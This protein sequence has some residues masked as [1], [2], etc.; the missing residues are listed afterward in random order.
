MKKFLC[1]CAVIMTFCSITK[2]SAQ[3]PINAPAPLDPAIRKGVL[4]NGLTYYIRHNEEPKNRASF[5]IVQNV[6]ALLENDSQ[7]GLA[8]FLEHMAFNGTKHFEGKGILNTLQNHGVEFGRNINAYTAFN[9]TVYNLSEVPTTSKGLVDSCLLVL[10]DWS[11]Y[12]A[13]TP[14]EI[15]SERG[16]ISEE[17]RTRRNAGFR[18]RQQF[19]PVLFKGSKYAVRDVIGDYDIINN[20][21]YDVLRAFYHDWYRTDLQCI[22]I[23]GDVDVDQIEAKVKEM[24]SKIPANKNPKERPF[25]EVPEHNE[26]Y[27]V[28]ALDKEMSSTSVDLYKIKRSTKNN[29][30][31]ISDMRQDMIAGLMNQ[32]FNARIQ[33]LLHKGDTPFINGNIS[34]SDFVRGYNAFNIHATI[35]PQKEEEGFEAILKEWE[36]AR[37]HGFLESELNRAKRNVLSAIE[38]KYKERDKISNDNYCRDIQWNFLTGEAVP[39]MEIEYQFT[40]AVLPSITVKDINALL[41]DW[42]T[43]ENRTIVISGP[44]EG[45]KH[46]T[47]EEAL[48]LVE[49]MKSI[50]VDPYVDTVTDKP[51]VDKK[52]ITKGQIV[53]EKLLPQFDAKEWTLSNGAK[54]VYRFADKNKDQIDLT[55]YSWGGTSTI[56]E[57]AKLP[58]ATFCTEF[59][60]NY[61]AGEFD[62]ITLE[63]ILTGK[64]VNVSMH[65]GNLKESISG[66]CVPKD[67]ETMMQLMYLKFESPRFDKAAFEA[68]K[69]R[70][71]AYVS[72]LSNNPDAIKGDSI[73]RI[74]TNYHPRT[75]NLSPKFI[76]QL[77]FETMKSVYL[78]RMQDAS[79]FTFVLVGNVEE[80]V[81]K[82]MVTTYIASLSSSNRK[83]NYIDRKVTFP[84][85][86]VNKV[87]PI[88]LETPKTTEFQRLH[89]YMPY[90]IYNETCLDII[91]AVLDLRFTE[92]V[93]EEAGGTYGVGVSA[94]LKQY[95]KSTAGLTIYFDC[96]PDRAEELI[97][98]VEAQI[99]EMIEKGISDVDYDKTVK[100]IKKNL[101]E[102]KNHNEYYSNLLATYMID[103]IDLTKEKS[104][105]DAVIAN[106]SKKDVE[107]FA[108]KFFK[109]AEKV[110]IEFVP[111]N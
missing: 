35:K 95:P 81:A 3:L 56:S 26:T 59:A 103:G 5:Y 77:D 75:M 68:L 72:S 86:D 110:H 85:K 76:E 22:I 15:D 45:E 30:A 44:T 16:V 43:P 96:K 9:E 27:F 71:A 97:K 40:K 108:R 52:E 62:A 32:M 106:I 82:E 98:I 84:K 24:F 74:I 107:K 100:N 20:F 38:S 93:R 109:K 55:G 37:R 31:T 25:F 102:S 91:K 94:T 90:S 70:Y 89:M 50:K 64:Q 4:D 61:G 48:A 2:V 111:K 104:N 34:A 41:A 12:L 101:E 33:E 78:N 6:G 105:P 58:S 80:K 69:G 83:E 51:I 13:L 46:M 7:N 10:N 42:S 28:Q 23:V 54:V 79:D 39:G 21:K 8:H 60:Q 67:F 19:F 29:P 18:V 17:W 73:S 14:E 36:R 99:D 63:K 53:S 65:I 1:L 87:I 92:K 66:S 47:Q 57:I 11:N 88:K 49:Q